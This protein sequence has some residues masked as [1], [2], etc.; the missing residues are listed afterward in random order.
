MSD[1]F[2]SIDFFCR[3]ILSLENFAAR[4]TPGEMH[5]KLND[6]LNAYREVAGLSTALEY[7]FF[8]LS[9]EVPAIHRELCLVRCDG[10]ST[11]LLFHPD[12]RGHYS[13]CSMVRRSAVILHLIDRMGRCPPAMQGGFICELGDNGGFPTVAFSSRSE[14]ACLVPD[15]DFFESH[16]YDLLRRDIEAQFVPWHLRR[17]EV[18]WRGSTTGVRRFAPPPPDAPDDFRWL[19]RLALCQAARQSPLRAYY[20]VGV[21]GIV[22]IDEPHLQARIKAADFLRPP[23][24]RLEFMRHKGVI[25]IDGHA[26]AWSA[27]FAAFLMGVCVFKVESEHGYR[28]WYYSQLQPFV[29]YVPVAADLSDLDAALLWLREHDR[30]ARAIGETGRAFARAI[31]FEA[32]LDESAARIKQW[33]PDANFWHRG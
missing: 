18:I 13:V 31:T 23:V 26:N 11:R 30:E 6:I 17:R 4:A 32:T 8:S 5:K 7:G 33:L 3:N 16:G 28:Q 10:D 20:D 9:D 25:V 19:Q 2:Q 1:F 22:H 21:T 12:W 27:L 14:K 24:P 29:H 15:P